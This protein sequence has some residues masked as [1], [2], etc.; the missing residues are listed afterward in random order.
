M[1]YFSRSYGD[2]NEASVP[3]TRMVDRKDAGRICD[4]TTAG[5]NG[6]LPG[7]KRRLIREGGSAS[8][9]SI[10]A[11][12][13]DPGRGTVSTVSP[14]Q[15]IID[16]VSLAVEQSGEEPPLVSSGC[17]FSTVRTERLW[18]RTLID[19]SVLMM[20]LDYTRIRALCG[21]QMIVCL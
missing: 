14:Q 19:E 18:L 20:L 11:R 17:F 1:V 21:C 5:D 12:P 8:R 6:P 7:G 4:D 2:L 10:H 9:V 3:T 13:W 15:T 16:D